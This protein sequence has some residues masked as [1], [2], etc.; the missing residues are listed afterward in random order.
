VADCRLA[1]IAAIAE[2]SA[3]VAAAYVQQ[4]K[5]DLK[6]AQ[7]AAAD[8]IKDRKQ[9]ATAKRWVEAAEAAAKSTNR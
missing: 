2:Q 7:D 6:R 4:A 5:A 8:D 3:F 1:A 9:V